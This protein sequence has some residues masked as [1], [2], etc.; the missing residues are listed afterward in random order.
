M[1][2][3]EAEGRANEKQVATCYRPSKQ[4]LYYSESVNALWWELWVID[5]MRHVIWPTGLPLP[6]NPDREARDDFQGQV[7]QVNWPQILDLDNIF[8]LYK[9]SLHSFAT[10]NKSEIWKQQQQQ[11]EYCCCPRF[12]IMCQA[13]QP[14][15][16]H[17][18]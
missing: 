16:K 15:K 18:M 6:V 10:N 8:F 2:S 13:F 4:A 12:S 5:V 14:Y 9:V 11:S 1:E 7:E 3:I 17:F